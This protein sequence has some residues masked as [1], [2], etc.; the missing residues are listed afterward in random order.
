MEN[1]KKK[2]ARSSYDPK[3]RIEKNNLLKDFFKKIKKEKQ[4]K[5]DKLQT[6]REKRIDPLALKEKQ[7]FLEKIKKE[8]ELEVKI[9]TDHRI[10]LDD[11][12][13]EKNIA[14]KTVKLSLGSITKKETKDIIKTYK[15]NDE[16]VNKEII[17][18]RQKNKELLNTVYNIKQECNHDDIF[19]YPAD[20]GNFMSTCKLCSRLKKW[21]TYEWIK[22]NTLKQGKVISQI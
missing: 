2:I 13:E 7:N 19:A 10:F 20:D 1:L 12:I 15:L 6:K 9:E 17:E 22:Y 8:K 18:K 14:K 3:D 4:N 11:A 21:S 5:T 16:R